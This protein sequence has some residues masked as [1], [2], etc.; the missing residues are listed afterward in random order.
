MG[1]QASDNFVE[2]LFRFPDQLAATVL[3][4]HLGVEQR[5]I[6]GLEQCFPYPQALNLPR[7][8]F[9]RLVQMAQAFTYHQDNVWLWDAINA[10]TEA[11]NHLAHDLDASDLSAKVE[12]FLTCVENYHPTTG[13]NDLRRLQLA[14]AW[15]CGLLEGHYLWGEAGTRGP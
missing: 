8:S 10:L 11:R 5:L 13:A 14:V 6:A 15:I 4:G 1:Q 7:Q 9:S 12:R 2:K 3:R